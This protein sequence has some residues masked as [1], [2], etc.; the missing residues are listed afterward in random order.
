[1]ELKDGVYESRD[2]IQQLL[3]QV[4]VR[5]AAEGGR[6]L[7]W[8]DADFADWPLSDPTLL[9]ALN[10]WALPHRRLHLLAT[11]YEPL[12]RAHPRFVQW[13]QLHD[14]VISAKSFEAS[15]PPERSQPSPVGVVLAPGLLVFKRWTATRASVSLGNAREEAT[16][17]EWF[18]AIEQRSTD[19]FAGTTLGL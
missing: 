1:M 17:R 10:A 14:R 5:S 2:Q 15:D 8:M 19:S 9:G 7:C 6:E 13:R 3:L 4:L 16:T 12:R 18:D 11:D